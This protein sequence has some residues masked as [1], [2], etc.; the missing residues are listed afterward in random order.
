MELL[1][2]SAS[3]VATTNNVG[4]QCFVDNFMHVIMYAESL[5]EL[6]HVLYLPNPLTCRSFGFLRV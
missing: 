6:E 3:T 1:A 2:R 4:V 5:K